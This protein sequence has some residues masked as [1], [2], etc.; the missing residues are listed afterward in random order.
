MKKE[1][2]LRAVDSGSIEA[3]CQLIGAV[4]SDVTTAFCANLER[5]PANSTWQHY[6]HILARVRAKGQHVGSRAGT[7]QEELAWPTS[8]SSDT[9]TR[10]YA[11]EEITE[12][13]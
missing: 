5:E 1:T 8:P 4:H 11:H 3:V 12:K 7:D 6:V 2:L 9:W 13:D 10:S